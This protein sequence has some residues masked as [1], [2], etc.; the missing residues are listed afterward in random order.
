[1]DWHQIQAHSKALEHEEN[2]KLVM[3]MNC[4]AVAQGGTAKDRKKMADII[5]GYDNTDF[6]VEEFESIMSGQ[7]LAST[8]DTDTK[9]AIKEWANAEFDVNDPAFKVK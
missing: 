2:E 9:T 6:N 8:E 1:M 7:F 5:L 4:M 3:L